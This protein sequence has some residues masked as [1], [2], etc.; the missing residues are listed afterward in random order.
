[1]SRK[2]SV[3]DVFLGNTLNR[4]S[5][6]IFCESPTH[7]NK[8]ESTNETVSSDETKS[9]GETVPGKTFRPRSDS[10]IALIDVLSVRDDNP[11]PP[12][13]PQ[14]IKSVDTY[15]IDLAK[16]SQNASV[17]ATTYT[18]KQ[19]EVIKW[20][21]KGDMF[22]VFIM[23]PFYIE[24]YKDRLSGVN[25]LFLMLYVYSMFVFMIVASVTLSL[26]VAKS[27]V[28]AYRDTAPDMLDIHKFNYERTACYIIA[29]ILLLMTIIT[30]IVS[31]LSPTLKTWKVVES[32]EWSFVTK[33]D[34]DCVHIEKLSGPSWNIYIRFGIAILF[35]F[36]IYLILMLSAVTYLYTITDELDILKDSFAFVFILQIDEY[37]FMYML[38]VNPYFVKI[39]RDDTFGDTIF[40]HDTNRTKK[41]CNHK[42]NML[43]SSVLAIIVLVCIITIGNNYLMPEL[44]PDKILTQTPLDITKSAT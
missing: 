4:V 22:N 14:S 7:V 8:T 6:K 43:L 10:K 44:F 13:T 3:A 32:G 1:M 27:T 9:S 23:L 34:G 41:R 38:L 18:C 19:E 36:L 37:V 25:I 16:L 39:W 29:S 26:I 42:I 11:T 30:E 17:S 21:R 33:R 31:S 28:K 24:K 40:V 15:S 20:I 2:V 12:N 35:Q 5:P